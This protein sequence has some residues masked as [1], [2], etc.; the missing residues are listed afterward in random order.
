MAPLQLLEDRKEI[1]GKRE[2]HSDSLEYR[3]SRFAFER[4]IS[5]GVLS[6]VAGDDNYAG[7]FVYMY[8]KGRNDY[9]KHYASGQVVVNYL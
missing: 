5:T 7:D 6:D 3:D 9:F 4:A 8:S 1:M 2:L